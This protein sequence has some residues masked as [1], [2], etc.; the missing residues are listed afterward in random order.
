MGSALNN[1]DW[2]SISNTTMEDNN[3]EVIRVEED[4]VEELR[5]D[6]ADQD[7]DGQALSESVSSTTPTSTTTNLS[8][9]DLT[10]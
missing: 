7:G 2:T 8:D 9:D 6:I 3:I 10:T 4:V 1:G 5:G